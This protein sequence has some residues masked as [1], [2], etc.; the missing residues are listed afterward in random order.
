MLF[1]SIELINA[2]SGKDRYT[3]ILA[4]WI[5]SLHCPIVHTR[6]QIPASSGIFLQNWFY[7]HG[8]VRIIAV[9]YGV[10]D[11][12]L[13][14]GIPS[15]HITV[16]YNGTPEEKY[17]LNQP[18]RI[19][20]LK[21]KYNLDPDGV[22][23]GCVSRKKQQEQLLQAL[24]FLKQPVTLF[25]I[26]VHE[27]PEW[28]LITDRYRVPH[29]IHYLGHI[30]QDD[31]L[32][33]YKLFNIKILP[34]VTEGISQAILEAMALSVPVIATR[35]AGNIDIIEH[36]YNGLL[37]NEGD[38][39]EMAHHIQ[40]LISDAQLREK[41]IRHGLHTATVKFSI[42]VTIRKYEQFFRDIINS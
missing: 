11:A 16:I 5:Y 37:F 23:L 22:V 9:S 2:Q 31:A 26:G 28:K 4:N 24:H 15:S 33:Y 35:A 17:N 27:R 38:T 3:S 14:L 8:T 39:K 41:L 29:K 36:G 20:E 1:R 19:E 10:R 6:R 32:Y 34:S 7:T 18:E 12:L 13:K 42:Q 25:L 40:T 21:V 30:E